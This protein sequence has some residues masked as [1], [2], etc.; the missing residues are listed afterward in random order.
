MSCCDDGPTGD[1]NNEMCYPI[2]LD[3][4]DE[5]YMEKSIY[6]MSFTRSQVCQC[7][8]IKRAPAIH[9]FYF[10]HIL[11]LLYPGDLNS[12]ISMHNVHF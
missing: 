5:H 8:V 1:M 6:C 9:F 3:T 7:I 10:I 12:K 4:D 2:K 11:K